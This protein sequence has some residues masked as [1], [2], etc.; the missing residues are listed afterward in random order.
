MLVLSSSQITR[1][2]FQLCPAGLLKTLQSC[3]CN[4]VFF[5][6]SLFWVEQCVRYRPR[7]ENAVA[8]PLSPGCISEFCSMSSQAAKEP[9]LVSLSL[10]ELLLDLYLNWTTPLWKACLQLLSPRYLTLHLQSLHVE[11]KPLP[12]VLC[13][14]QPSPSASQQAPKLSVCHLPCPAV[15][16]TTIKFGACAALIGTWRC[17]LALTEPYGHPGHASSMSIVGSRVLKTQL[18]IVSTSP[19]PRQSCISC[20]MS[21]S[22]PQRRTSIMPEGCG[23][24]VALAILVLCNQASIQQQT[25]GDL[26][27]FECLMHQLTPTPTCLWSE[28]SSGE[29]SLIPMARACLSTWAR[30]RLLPLPVFPVLHYL[31][32]R[33]P[34]KGPLLVH[35]DS[36]LLNRKQFVKGVKFTLSVA[37]IAHQG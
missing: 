9:T 18:R 7:K 23:Q 8:D 13:S 4:S 19:S 37:Q 1:Q 26:H 24:P 20:R 14:V 36:S 5:P 11:N 12:Q 6:G 2:S 25:Q 30:D 15:S 28:S 27:P 21:G 32:F 22:V 16:K 17:W 34:G 35:Y 33:F 29:P 3:T 31:L 10:A